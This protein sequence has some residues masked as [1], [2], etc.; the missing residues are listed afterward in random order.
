MQLNRR[1]IKWL[2]AG[3]FAFSVWLVWSYGDLFWPFPQFPERGTIGVIEWYADRPLNEAETKALKMV[4]ERLED[5]PVGAT[6]SRYT[7]LLCGDQNRYA[8]MAEKV[9]KP[10]ATQGFHLHPLGYS[11]ISLPFVESVRNKRKEHYWYTVASGELVHVILHEIAHEW[12]ADEVGFWRNRKL[13]RWKM[14]GYCEYL[15]GS[16][17]KRNN[18]DYQPRHRYQRYARG[19]FDDLP[20]G[21]KFYVA[22]GLAMEYLIDY[23]EWTP[24]EVFESE[25]ELWE[26]LDRMR[27]WS[28]NP[29]TG[30]ME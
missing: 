15:A 24:E 2:V 21:R 19:D 9:G 17:G 27:G 1:V 8:Q 12:I 10:S 11:F 5:L 7:I 29:T 20:E 16:Y 18:S 3:S 22:A 28:E 6:D 23:G 4:G 25:F 30:E 26:V 13:A 14:E